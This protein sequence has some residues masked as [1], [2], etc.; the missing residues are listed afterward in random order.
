MI[1]YSGSVPRWVLGFWVSVDSVNQLPPEKVKYGGSARFWDL[2]FGF[3][4]RSES[5]RTIERESILK[6][7]ALIF[8]AVMASLPYSFRSMEREGL[9]SSPILLPLKT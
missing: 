3:M 9:K 4:F 8:L 2:G 5:R 6:L 1:K 7:R